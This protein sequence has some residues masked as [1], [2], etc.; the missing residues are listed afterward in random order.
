M[1]KTL[2]SVILGCLIISAYAGAADPMD[3]PPFPAASRL[4]PSPV[5]QDASI[6]AVWQMYAI[7]PGII[8]KDIRH[9]RFSNSIMPPVLNGIETVSFNSQADYIISTDA[10]ATFHQGRAPVTATEKITCVSDSGGVA[11]YTTEMLSMNI[12]GGDLTSMGIMI[13]ES[14]T[15]ASVGGIAIETLPSD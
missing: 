6:G 1:K 14:P 4:L 9:L 15:K 13:R 7:G 8:I 2:F 11:K 3:I 12:S 10:G 5:S